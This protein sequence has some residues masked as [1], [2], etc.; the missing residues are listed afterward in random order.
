MG[1]FSPTYPWLPN[2]LRRKEG[3][4]EFA[5]G[6]LPLFGL[7][8]TRMKGERKVIIFLEKGGNIMSSVGH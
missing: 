8:L 1:F 4:M 2:F 7:R 5:N 6:F 3:V